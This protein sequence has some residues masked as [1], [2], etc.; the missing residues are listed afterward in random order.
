MKIQK[1]QKSRKKIATAVIIAVIFILGIAA[2]YYYL[3]RASSDKTTT[4]TNDTSDSIHTSDNEQAQKLQDTPETKQQA[5]N[6][7]KPAAPTTSKESAKKQVQLTASTNTADGMVYVRG[8]V[9]Y[10]V[11][12]GSCYALLTG[13]TGQSIRK[14]TTILQNAA[15]TDCKTISIPVSELS[16]GKWVFVLHYTSDIYEGASNEVS[17]TI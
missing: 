4:G 8:G 11:S 14:G 9:N 15:S 10:P 7:D 3:N 17:F 13:P 12:D 1:M 16:P 2:M 5:P 6:T